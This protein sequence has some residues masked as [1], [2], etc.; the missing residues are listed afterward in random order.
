MRS[1]GKPLA[2]RLAPLTVLDER[3]H[4][5]TLG[6]LWAHQP[7]VLAFVRHFG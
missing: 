4:A 2:A 6:G 3:G 7:T 1:M 5:V